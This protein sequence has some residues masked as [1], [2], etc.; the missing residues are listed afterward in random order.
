MKI[1][2]L[3]VKQTSHME[4]KEKWGFIPPIRSILSPIFIRCNA[5]GEINWKKAPVYELSELKGKTICICK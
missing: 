5:K 4:L 3:N 2:T 1:R